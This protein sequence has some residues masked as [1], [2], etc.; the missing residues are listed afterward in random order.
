MDELE[1]LERRLTWLERWG[2]VAAAIAGIAAAGLYV[3]SF[4]DVGSFMANGVTAVFVIVTGMV[5]LA[6]TFLSAVWETR[7]DRLR[8]KPGVP[9]AWARWR[10]R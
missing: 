2:L 5:W 1:R 8:R 9:D 10:R 3:K 4:L 6:V 7:V